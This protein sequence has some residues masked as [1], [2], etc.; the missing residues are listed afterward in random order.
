MTDVEVIVDNEITSGA[1][2]SE[3]NVLG[4]GRDGRIN[5]HMALLTGKMARRTG[6]SPPQTSVAEELSEVEAEEK[7]TGALQAADPHSMKHKHRPTGQKPPEPTEEGVSKTP[8]R[9]PTK[10][11]TPSPVRID[12]NGDAWELED[13]E[14]QEEREE[15]RERRAKEMKGPEVG[16]IGVLARG[17]S[18]L[19]VRG[20]N[21]RQNCQW[22]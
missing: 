16:P 8:L 11:K 9:T 17:R 13:D 20:S 21:Q 4:G 3:K 22:T 5:G 18:P 14:A 19:R 6:A 15:Q 12:K 10:G 2:P 7:V 1:H